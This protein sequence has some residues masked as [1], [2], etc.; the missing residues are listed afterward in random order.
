MKILNR[1]AAGLFFKMTPVNI[2][3][4]CFHCQEL[5]RNK[6]NTLCAL[7]VFAVNT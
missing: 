5:K 2:S 4:I 3:S 6:K 7:C 1:F